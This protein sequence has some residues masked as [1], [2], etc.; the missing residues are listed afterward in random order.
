MVS[1]SRIFGG[2]EPVLRVV[3]RVESFTPAWVHPM[4]G[5]SLSTD[6]LPGY[7]MALRTLPFTFD[8]RLFGRQLPAGA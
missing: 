6:A 8:G 3:G 5:R 7:T 4:H 1:S 2:A